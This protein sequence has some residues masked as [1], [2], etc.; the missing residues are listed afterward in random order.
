VKSLD[1]FDFAAIMALN[2][3]LGLE[4]ARGEFGTL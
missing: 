1:R 4:L 2:K 3:M